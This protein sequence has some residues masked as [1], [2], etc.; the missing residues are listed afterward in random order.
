VFLGELGD[1]R[2]YPRARSI[3]KLA[4]L[5]LYPNR[6]GKMESRLKIT[7]RGRSLLRKMAYQLAVSGDGGLSL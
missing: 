2:K 5:N 1:L 3:E 7:H 4:G 6:S